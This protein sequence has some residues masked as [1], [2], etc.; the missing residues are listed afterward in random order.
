MN[1]LQNK[2]KKLSLADHIRQ[3]VVYLFVIIIFPTLG[4]IAYIKLG[5]DMSTETGGLIGIGVVIISAFIPYMLYNLLFEKYSD[6]LP[7]TFA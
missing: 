7:D 3:A 1:I 2:R 4:L 6:D 5:G